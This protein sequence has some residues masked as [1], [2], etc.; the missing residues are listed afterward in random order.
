[1]SIIRDIRLITAQ[2]LSL[3]SSA[4]H[5]FVELLNV[6]DME[7]DREGYE[8]GDA[9]KKAMQK[10]ER[11][12]I[13]GDDLRNITNEHDIFGEGEEGD[14]MEMELVDIDDFDIVDETT[15]EE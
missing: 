11:T 8:P 6:I 9:V 15:E 4:R 3:P 14:V 5:A 12:L 10:L 1:M 13:D 7:L 2:H